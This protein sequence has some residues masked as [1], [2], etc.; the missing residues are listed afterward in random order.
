MRVAVIQTPGSALNAWRDS[1]ASLERLV[2]DAAAEH[3][4]LVVLPECAFPA[5]VLDSVDA[6]WTA[7]EA[8]MPG[9]REF[10]ARPCEW[11]RRGK[12]TLCISYVAERDRRLYNAA[13]LVTPDGRI[14]GTHHKCFM[15]D[16]DRLWFT[17]GETIDPCDTDLGRIG[18]MICADARL[19]EIPATLAARGAQFIAQPTAWVNTGT[20]EKPTNPQAEFL[21]AARAREFGVAVAS[22][23]KYGYEGQTRFIGSSLICD[24]DG[25]VLARAGTDETTVIAADVLLAPPKPPH[26]TS[27]ELV[28]LAET[29]A[30]AQSG[31]LPPLAIFL[32]PPDCP[33][34]KAE[35]LIAQRPSAQRDQPLLI[36]SPAP[37]IAPASSPHTL[38][39]SDPAP[40]VHTLAG[41]GVGAVSAA[42]A[43]RF[44]PIRALALRGANLAV[45]F[46]A[47]VGE[48]ELRARAL[49]NRI[50]VL[51]VGGPEATL[52]A[53]TGGRCALPT[54]IP[55]ADTVDKCVAW[56]T[57]VLRDRTPGLYQFA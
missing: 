54:T 17:P 30:D 42:D 44:A 14:A 53:P 56:K 2:R 22:A 34:S 8:G 19:P 50:Y 39:V 57:D 46:G 48:I 38:T 51:A 55:V 26:V 52:Y 47:G 12:L 43:A 11:A 1:L 27:E 31:D 20:P 24:A 7:R 28:A 10:L 21:I 23:S 6:Y 29:P 33:P 35:A 40:S 32:L 15:W 13:S 49:E 16:F 5:Y 4:E 37:S 25:V 45:V 3:A 41:I 36:V 18:M 9:D